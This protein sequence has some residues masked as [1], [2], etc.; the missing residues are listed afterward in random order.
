MILI[1]VWITKSHIKSSSATWRASFLWEGNPRNAPVCAPRYNS[2]KVFLTSLFYFRYPLGKWSP[3]TSRREPD[4]S[5]TLSR[6][7]SC[8]EVKEFLWRLLEF[9]S[10][11][12]QQSKTPNNCIH[13]TTSSLHMSLILQSWQNTKPKPFLVTEMHTGKSRGHAPHGFFKKIFVLH[14][15]LKVFFKNNY[16]IYPKL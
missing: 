11:D 2:E 6:Y 12:S 7:V 13:W 3:S 1:D 15:H 8:R 16:F 10:S 9:D 14:A 5:R 4:H